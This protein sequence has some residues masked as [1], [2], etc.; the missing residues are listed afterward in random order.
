MSPLKVGVGNAQK[1]N[2]FVDVTVA[3]GHE[4]CRF[5][6]HREH[7]RERARLCVA[8]RF[9]FCFV[10][11]FSESS[12]TTATQA[13]P[14][15]FSPPSS[16]KVSLSLSLRFFCFEITLL[17]LSLSDTFAGEALVRSLFLKPSSQRSTLLPAVCSGSPPAFRGSVKIALN[18][19]R[20]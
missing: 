20:T 13:L 15:L 9:L 14:P 17:S 11:P 18:L 8:N 1:R 4:F 10:E 7:A 5:E 19:S 16:I 6:E 12:L 3:N 2:G